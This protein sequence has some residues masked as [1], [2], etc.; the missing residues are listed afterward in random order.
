LISNVSIKNTI[1]NGVDMTMLRSGS[2]F[3]TSE[4]DLRWNVSGQSDS[5]GGFTIPRECEEMIEALA[6]KYG[7]K[8]D[9]L[10]WSYMKD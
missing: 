4:S 10:S 9:D 1:L 6:L 2:W 7:E 8:P 5:V 3:L